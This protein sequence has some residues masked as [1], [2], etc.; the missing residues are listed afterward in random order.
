[1]A[2][3]DFYANTDKMLA[4]MDFA[5]VTAAQKEKHQK[6]TA[7]LL[8]DFLSI[9]DSLQ[10]LETH[11]EELMAN[12]HE[13]V[14]LRSVRAVLRQTLGVLKEAG[15]TPINAE[16][17]LLDLDKHEVVAVLTDTSVQEDTV[18]EETERGYSWNKR[19]LRRAK[20]VVAHCSHGGEALS[21]H[22]K[23]TKQ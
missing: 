1:M 19:L 3:N 8:Y 18:L 22:P 14:P 21:N 4:A 10:A 20:V 13:H 12:G 2:E 9:V 11:C 6:A 5:E 17:Q 15:V 16:G 23:G 7:G